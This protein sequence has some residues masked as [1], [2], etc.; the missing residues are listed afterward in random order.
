MATNMI[1]KWCCCC[2]GVNDELNIPWNKMTPM[3]K[4]YRAKQ[5]WR[6]ARLVY[7]FIKIKFTAMSLNSA[8]GKDGEPNIDEDVDLE[9][10]NNPNEREWKWYIIRQ[11]N[12]LP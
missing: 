9:N 2:L 7:H 12:T 3:Q 5:L 4:K 11:E 6:R 10:I 1:T 8:L